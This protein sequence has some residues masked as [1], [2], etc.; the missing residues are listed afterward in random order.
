MSSSRNTHWCHR[1]RR[2]VQLR[3]RDAVC[4]YCE[5]GFVQELDGIGP[6]DFLGL[7][8]DDHDNRFGIMEA[9]SAL[10]RQRMG[11]RNRDFDL[12]GR[13]GIGPD[14]GLAGLGAGYGAGPWLIFRGQVPVR[15]SENGGIEVLFNGG[16][17]VGLRRANVGDYFLG[18]GLDEL[19]E[20]LTRNDRHGPPPASRS[21]ID[22]MPTVKITQRHLRTDSHCPVCKDRFELGSEVRQMPCNHIYHS[23][24]IIP[25][26]V[27]HNSC[28][29]CRHEMP[30]Q[31]SSGSGASNRSSS[32]G[33]NSSG[34][35]SNGDNQGR[36]NP[37]SFL[38]PFRSSNSN[39]NSNSQRTESSGSSSAAVRE[40]NH[41]ISYSGWPFDY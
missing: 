39:S 10:M 15:M 13:S 20:Q 17:G 32:G 18:P 4:P 31:G 9:F 1:C 36:R 19:I 21:S 33:G 7:D 27:Q 34:R 11:R 2:P 38:W 26:L 6:F 8:D 41:Q 40:D 35:E 16:P 25:W 23:D 5:G 29:V 24:C 28:P 30:P 37:F 12:R 3:G 14:H 22:A